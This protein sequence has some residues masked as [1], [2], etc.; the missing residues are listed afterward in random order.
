M[1]RQRSPRGR[2]AASGVVP[3]VVLALVTGLLAIA[4]AIWW[5]PALYAS[6]LWVDGGQP[7]VSPTFFDD[8]S[9]SSSPTGSSQGDG[10]VGSAAAA[11]TGTDPTATGLARALGSI[12]ATGMGTVTG[13]VQDAT[14]GKVLWQQKSTTGQV[15]A[16]TMKLLTCV[17]ALQ[18]LGPDATFTTRVAQPSA[19]GIVLVGGGDPYLA[20]V[21]GTGYPRPAAT[22]T[23]AA[24]TAAAL[25]AKG[26]TKVTLGYDESLFTGP[27]WHPAWPA[28]YHDQ[29]ST[30]GALWVD[31]GVPAAGQQPSATPGLTAATIFAAQLKAN[32]ITVA[33]P[34]AATKAATTAPTVASVSSLPVRTLV[35]QT[36]L[37]SD[38]S[39][40]EVLARHVG[41][42]TGN[43]GSFTGAVKGV[44]AELVALGSWRTGARLTD[45][46]GLSRSNL[47][48]AAMLTDVLHRA[49]TTPKLSSLLEGLPSA[50]V[51]GTLGS[52]FYTP[53]STAGRGTVTAKTGTL[54]G[55]STLAGHVRSRSGGDLVFAFMANNPTKEWEVREYLDQLSAT[56]AGCGC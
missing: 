7:T 55:V 3:L 16:S 2:S 46:S 48:P 19:T 29:V 25:K 10:V 36:L 41:V 23:L 45:G 30:I 4:G 20:S 33:G 27:G 43:G 37:H 1:T 13:I 9:A 49:A 31:K 53:E 24:Q 17:A 8:P 34:P 50:G 44:Q 35:A 52:R 47:V 18:A 51:T 32:G 56:V 21:P 42:A 28:S 5:R 54:T 38:N 26:I 12:P 11:P 22:A 39:A 6:G 14:T 15:P 40:A